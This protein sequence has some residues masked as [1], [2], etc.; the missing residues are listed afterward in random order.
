MQTKQRTIMAYSE[1]PAN[2]VFRAL[3]P[4]TTRCSGRT[5]ANDGVYV[6]MANSHAM[7]TASRRDVIFALHM[8][9]RVVHRDYNRLL[10]RHEQDMK[11]IAGARK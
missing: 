2:S 7:H 11:I 3:L 5:I 10:D 6:K 8:P 4:E 9:C 1:V